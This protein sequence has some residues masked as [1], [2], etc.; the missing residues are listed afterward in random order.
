LKCRWVRFFSDYTEICRKVEEAPEEPE[1]KGTILGW[2][3]CA[4]TSSNYTEGCSY[5]WDEAECECRGDFRPS[6]W[7]R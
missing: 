3:A 7:R 6:L 1:E 5:D 2:F 4:M